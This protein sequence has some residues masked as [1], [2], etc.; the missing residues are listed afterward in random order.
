MGP[1]IC[2]FWAQVSCRA[3]NNRNA[4]NN[5]NLSHFNLPL[6]LHL[7]LILSPTFYFPL[8]L[9]LKLLS[10]LFLFSRWFYLFLSIYC[11]LFLCSS[12]HYMFF[13]FISSMSLLCFLLVTF[14]DYFST[15]NMETVLSFETPINFYRSKWRHIPPPNR[16]LQFK[17]P[18]M[19]SYILLWRICLHIFVFLYLGYELDIQGMWVRLLT[20]VADSSP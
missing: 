13:S 15:L 7:I 19:W 5:K 2:T 6:L 3:R 9:S 11:F 12:F 17:S 1:Q 4:Y 8:L 20:E 14:W 18:W 10:F 16:N